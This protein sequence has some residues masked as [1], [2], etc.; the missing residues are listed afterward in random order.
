VSCVRVFAN[1]PLLFASEQ[2]SVFA[3]IYVL[4]LCLCKPVSMSCTSKPLWRYRYNRL[5]LCV[6]LRK[7][8]SM[9]CTSK[10]L[11]RYRYNRLCLCVRLRKPVSMSCT[12]KPLSIALHICV[13]IYAYACDPQAGMP[14]PEGLCQYPSSLRLRT[15]SG[16]RVQGLGLRA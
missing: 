9:S 16:L 14:L 11:W 8:V 3:N 5:C 15:G 10:P 4:C 1:I 6:R 2:V 7:P 12:S 13:C